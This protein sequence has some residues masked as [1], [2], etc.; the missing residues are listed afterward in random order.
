[1]EDL[2][3]ESL[4]RTS[5]LL[6]MLAI[7]GGMALALGIVGIYGV[8]VYVASQRSR[9]I[10]IRLALGAQQHHVRTMFL[11]HGLVL[12]GVGITIGLVAA[13]AV[14]RLL[15]SLLFG[16]APTDPVGYAA[17][18][19]VI[20]AAAALACYLPARRAAAVEPMETLKAE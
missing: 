19:G 3:S 11:R 13:L 4:A 20:V 10:G 17:A 1:M 14:T 9:E 16:I 18:L 7:A 8:I 5:F 6:V 12:T 2:Y 15:S